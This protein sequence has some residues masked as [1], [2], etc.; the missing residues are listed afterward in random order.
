MRMWWL[1]LGVSVAAWGCVSSSSVQCGDVTCPE[2]TE[3][4]TLTA[5]EEHLCATKTQIEQC[6]GHDEATACDAGWCHDGVCIPIECGNNRTDLTEVCDDGNAITGDGTCSGDC[7]STEKCGNSLVDPLKLDMMGEKVPNEEC[8]DGNFVSGDGCSSTCLREQLRWHELDP[9]PPPAMYDMSMVYDATRSR[10]VMFGGVIEE[11]GKL[12]ALDRTYEWNGAGWFRVFTNDGPS[13]RFG[14]GMY[15]DPIRRRTVL[16]GGL[17]GDDG[18]VAFGDMWE[19]DGRDWTYRTPPSVSPP[20]RGRFG[21]AYDGKR[22]VAVLFGGTDFEG[23]RSDTWEWDGTAWKENT[24]ATHPPAQISPV[25]VYDPKRSVI[26]MAG[27]TEATKETWEYDGAWHKITTTTPPELGR[28][29]ATYVPSLGG[30]LVHGGYNVGTDTR[31][32]KTYLYTGSTWQDLNTTSPTEGRDAAAM[33]AIPMS[34]MVVMY[35]GTT[36]ASGTPTLYSLDTWFFDSA[37]RSWTLQRNTGGGIPPMHSMASAYD[38]A[39]HTGWIYGGRDSAGDQTNELW[40]FDGE[41]WFSYTQA[42]P[43][44]RNGAGLA[45]DTEHKQL[46]LFGGATGTGLAP[47]DTWA[48]DDSGWTNV[49]STVSPS[50]RGTAAMTYDIHRKKVVLQGG[51]SLTPEATTWEWNG[52]TWAPSTPTPNPGIRGGACAIYDP[53]SQSVLLTAGVPAQPPTVLTDMWS[54]NGTSWTALTMQVPFEMR[55]LTA[56]AYVGA[57]KSVMMFGGLGSGGGAFQDLWEYRGSTWTRLDT[58]VRPGPRT[59]HAMFPSKTGDGIVVFGGTARFESSSLAMNDVWELESTSGTPREICT[60]EKVDNDGDGL[61][62]CADL[63]CWTTCSP[64]C[65]PGVACDMSLSRCGDGACNSAL[66]SCRSCPG[67]CGPCTIVCG[68]TYCDSG[69]TTTACPGDCP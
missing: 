58:G 14:P 33:I 15:Y 42:G 9:S 65:P 43:S 44:P 39:T 1:V 4:R 6:N 67:D 52:V 31:S 66:E 45:Y 19:W 60:D 16:Y 54:Y 38:P 36:G 23:A 20:R 26:V 40:A 46:I 50:P 27:G 69:E 64:F 17:V 53:S 18:D 59:G 47:A 32:A 63:D 51:A 57:R 12:L 10:I 48:Y 29:S 55:A 28:S 2:N 22:K 61:A 30:V 41:T 62:G 21:F 8:D 25:F 5:P 37:A 35:G 49:S 56:L 7:S 34:S 3:C 13:A 24:S 68:D 11:N